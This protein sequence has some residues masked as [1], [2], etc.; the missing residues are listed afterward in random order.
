[1][2]LFKDGKG[3]VTMPYELSPDP[4]IGAR[5]DMMDRSG[6]VVGVGTIV[7]PTYRARDDSVPRW[8]VTV[9]M[10]DPDLT[11]E[12]RACARVNQI[13]IPPRQIDRDHHG[14]WVGGQ[15]RVIAGGRD[16]GH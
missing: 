16:Y 7:H 6:K 13:H 2:M 5:A 11:Y 14:L 3:Y 4:T 1:M 8:V 9:E 10:D 15:R 12:V